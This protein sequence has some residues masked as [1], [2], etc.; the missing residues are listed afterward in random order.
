MIARKTVENSEC[1]NLSA[2][3]SR[4]EQVAKKWQKYIY[5]CQW[6]SRVVDLR[7]AD[8]TVAKT[9]KVTLAKQLSRLHTFLVRVK[10][11]RYSH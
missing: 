10:A 9:S 1:Q 4:S 5:W 6:D 8:Q 7:A 3:Q 11:V 2:T